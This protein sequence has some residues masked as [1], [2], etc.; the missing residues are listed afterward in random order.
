MR[1]GHIQRANTIS[2]G[3]H[4]ALPLTAHLYLNMVKLS[5]A[6]REITFEPCDAYAKLL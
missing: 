6:L 4:N 3:H 1:L 5:I 2:K